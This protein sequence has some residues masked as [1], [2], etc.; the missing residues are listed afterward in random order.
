MSVEDVRIVIRVRLRTTAPV[1]G[2][3]GLPPPENSRSQ[4]LSPGQVRNHAGPT[5]TVLRRQGVRR[6]RPLTRAVRRAPPEGRP[7]VAHNSASAVSHRYGVK[8]WNAK[9]PHWPLNIRRH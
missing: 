8:Y 2:R 3:H 4:K 9:F 1:W 5:E 6:Q 7:S